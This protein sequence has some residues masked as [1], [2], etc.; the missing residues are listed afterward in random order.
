MQGINFIGNK[1]TRSPPNPQ[2]DLDTII[3]SSI[4][5]NTHK[6]IF[7]LA[8]F[9]FSPATHLYKSLNI[10]GLYT[11]RQENTIHPQWHKSVK[12]CGILDILAGQGCPG[13]L[14]SE[15][16]QVGSMLVRL[17]AHRHSD[18]SWIQPCTICV[19]LQPNSFLF[20][21]CKSS[22]KLCRLWW[23]SIP[24]CREET[25]C[26]PIQTLPSVSF[27]ALWPALHGWGLGLV[28]H[29]GHNMFQLICLY[30]CTLSYRRWAS[31]GER[32]FQWG[33]VLLRHP[34]DH[35]QWNHRSQKLYWHLDLWLRVRTS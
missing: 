31:P 30:K 7:S 27:L 5:N 34:L 29:Y 11:G 28:H 23:K 1:T 32:A 21:H 4:K 9:F 19:G 22:T 14:W 13:L 16:N 6:G 20:L 25:V 17:Y 8:D 15:L 12:G 18:G 35:C 3:Q 33:R 24:N 2:Y 10:D 26:F